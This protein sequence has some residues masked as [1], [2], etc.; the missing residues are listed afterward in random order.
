M[1]RGRALRKLLLSYTQARMGAVMQSAACNRLHLL[2][3]PCARCLLACHDR[4]EAVA[5]PMTHEFLL[6]AARDRASWLTQSSR[7]QDGGNGL[8]MLNS[9]W[10]TAWTT[11]A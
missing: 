11:T 10:R 2:E 4:A 3:Q 8:I 7:T 6:L 5:F 1:A 9:Q